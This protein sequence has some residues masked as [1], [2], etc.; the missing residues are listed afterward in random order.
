MTGHMQLSQKSSEF[1]QNFTGKTKREETARE[2]VTGGVSLNDYTDF[3][4]EGVDEIQQ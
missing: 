4:R 1:I 2:T 3:G